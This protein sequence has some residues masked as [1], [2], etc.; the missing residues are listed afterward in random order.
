[1]TSIRPAFRTDLLLIIAIA[2]GTFGC[3]GISTG[4]S[5]GGGSGGA[6]AGG[7][8]GSNPPPSVQLWS[9]ILDPSRAT[10][11]TQAGIP[12]GI[13][14]R[15]TVCRTVAPSAKTDATD[16]TNIQN[17]LTACAGTD[18]V[19]QLQAGRYT[20][21]AGIFF[22]QLSHVVLRGAGPDKTTLAFT[23]LSACGGPQSAVC[24]L[25][26]SGW[27]ESYPGATAWTGGYA[28][29]TT[30]LTVDSTAG[31]SSIPGALGNIITLDQREDSIGICPQT[32]GTGYCSGTTGASEGG[33]TATIVTSLPH[34]FA[35]GNKVAVGEVAVAGYN[36]SSNT[37]GP[38]DNVVGCQWWT[39]TDIGC[40]ISGSY[41]TSAGCAANPLIAFRYT[42]PSP[43][44]LAPSGGG[45]AAVDTGG[46]FQAGITSAT[47][48]AG[49]PQGSRTCPGINYEP[50]GSPECANGEISRRS[51]METHQ[52]TKV[53][54]ETHVEIAPPIMNTNWRS[55]QNP[56]IW[57]TSKAMLVGVE[58]MTLDFTNDG[59]SSHTGGVIFTN[60]FQCWEQN[61]RSIAANRNHIWITYSMQMQ[62]QNNYFWGTKAGH[63]QSYGVEDGLGNGSNLIENNICQHVVSCYMQ[64]GSYG[65]VIAYNYAVDSGY[66][67]TDW[68][69]GLVAANHDYSGL[70]LFEGNDTNSFNL[71][72]IHGTSS[73]HTFFRN[74]MRGFDTPLRTN[75]ESLQAVDNCA[76]NRAE[77]YVGNILGWPSLETNYQAT[78]GPPLFPASVIWGL[79]QQCNHDTVPA[80]HLVS[81]TLLRWGNYDVV[82][83]TV[84][85]C[86][87]SFDPGWSTT[88]NSSSEIPTTGVPYVQGNAVPSSTTLPASFYLSSQPAFWTT[89]WGTPKWPPIGP[90]VIGGTAPDGVGGYSDAIPAQ[91]CYANTPVDPSF[92]RILAVSAGTWGNETIEGQ[93]ATLKTSSNTLGSRDVVTISGVSPS[94]Y[95]GIYQVISATSTSVT[96]SMSDNPGTYE[97]GGII[98]SPNIL[99]F[100]AANCYP[101]E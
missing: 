90:D 60:C 3:T 64:A 26:G 12:G 89:T 19:V 98:T 55:G 96:V 77:N 51:Q 74:R 33:T 43:G 83:G 39:I 34:G 1:M 76:F 2:F 5:G 69:I 25:G 79:D 54:D 59:G 32:G 18:Q 8:G 94:G 97:S 91:L 56:G 63:S 93:A 45:F 23:G 80:D 85:W 68:N 37:S 87:N 14:N 38:C 86:G 7:D 40:I 57:W 61:I 48:S 27:V 73:Q 100:N 70:D 88:C 82:T 49:S 81:Q 17:A 30:T 44:G 16:S 101:N 21:S 24:V 10:D 66:S 84:R 72:N 6:G 46:I 9:E 22:N 4:R 36:T 78:I 71:D 28:Q 53:I 11:W 35:V 20:L 92:Q 58:A 75:P 67:P 15:T 65:D 99:N 41:V 52:V 29:G 13:P 42:T 50:G 47:L 31:M 62:I 95:N